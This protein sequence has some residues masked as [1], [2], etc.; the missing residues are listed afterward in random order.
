MHERIRQVNKIVAIVLLALPLL[1]GCEPR[2]TPP[3]PNAIGGTIGGTSYTMLAW[4]EGL[5]ILLWSDIV[6]TGGSA[7][8]GSTEDEVYRQRGDSQAPDG[9]SYS[10]S[11]ETRDG[12]TADFA[13]DGT[14]YDLEEG[15]LFIVTTS[16]ERN[17]VRQ[18]GVDLSA[19]PTTNEGIERFGQD[20]P[21]IATFI[22]EAGGR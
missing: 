6:G 5:R 15:T 4:D 22:Q 11:L 21:A 16:G 20:E 9:R 17:S 2:T 14:P 19:I 7:G 12:V 3:G 8:S 13:I 18:L 1:S 10:Y